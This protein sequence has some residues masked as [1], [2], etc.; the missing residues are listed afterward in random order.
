MPKFIKAISKKSKLLG[1]KT[2]KWWNMIIKKKE[3][4][5]KNQ[6]KIDPVEM[7]KRELRQRMKNLQYKESN[8][9]VPEGM[10]ICNTV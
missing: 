2:K 8:C 1:K 4:N 10:A 3:N 6:E 9:I 7:K 5:Q